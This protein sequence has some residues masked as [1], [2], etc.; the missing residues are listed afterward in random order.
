VAIGSV[1]IT[2]RARPSPVL[3]FEGRSLWRGSK[4]YRVNSGFYGY[5]SCM[6][7]DAFLLGGGGVLGAAKVGMARAWLEFAATACGNNLRQ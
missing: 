3:P 2:T 5:S 6:T 7:C 1:A 4:I